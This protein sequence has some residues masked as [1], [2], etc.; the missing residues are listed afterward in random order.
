MYQTIAP[1]CKKD[2]NSA[3]ARRIVPSSDCAL[4]SCQRRSKLARRKECVGQVQKCCN[5]A[6]MSRSWSLTV[7][8]AVIRSVLNAKE[9][10][11]FAHHWNS[12]PA[13]LRAPNPA[14]D[15]QRHPMQLCT[16]NHICASRLNICKRS[17][18]SPKRLVPSVLTKA[19]IHQRNHHL[20]RAGLSAYCI[21]PLQITR[22]SSGACPIFGGASPAVWFPRLDCFEARLQA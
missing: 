14:S 8:D 16:V 17:N 9:M 12:L 21:L 1:R 6:V 22:I 13:A 18:S 19:A 2:N 7:E 4:A 3:R 15:A 20:D 5:A 10:T 11:S